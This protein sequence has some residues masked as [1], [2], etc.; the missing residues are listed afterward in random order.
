MD[1]YPEELKRLHS[2]RN[3]KVLLI[4]L[5]SLLQVGCAN[6]QFYHNYIMVG[7]V[8]EVS[9]KEVI[10]CIGNTSGLQPFATFEVYRSVFIDGYTGEGESLYEKQ[11]IGKIQLKSITD[12]HYMKAVVIQGEVKAYDMVELLGD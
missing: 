9:E 6:S 3:A 12:S 5:L 10:A 11:L 7:Q 8:V 4:L 1:V 2:L